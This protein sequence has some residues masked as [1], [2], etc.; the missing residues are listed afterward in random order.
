[1]IR[2]NM[3]HA[4]EGSTRYLPQSVPCSTQVVPESMAVAQSVDGNT[5]RGAIMLRN[6]A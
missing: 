4:K 5:G 3:P 2:A 1:M 6:V